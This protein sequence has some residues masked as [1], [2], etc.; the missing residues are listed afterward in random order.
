MQTATSKLL[1]ALSLCML[2]PTAVAAD[3]AKFTRT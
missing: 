3:D 2:V 1:V